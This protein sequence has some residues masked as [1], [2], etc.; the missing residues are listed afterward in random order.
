MIGLVACGWEEESSVVE[1]RMKN[2]NKRNQV[3]IEQVIQGSHMVSG[4]HCPAW[5]DKVEM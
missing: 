5:G 1:Q 2:Q 4:T 3:E